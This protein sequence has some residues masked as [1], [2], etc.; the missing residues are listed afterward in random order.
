MA[1]PIHL[2]KLLCHYVEL[3]P[4][5]QVLISLSHADYG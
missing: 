2:G 4:L 5:I 1:I 3:K